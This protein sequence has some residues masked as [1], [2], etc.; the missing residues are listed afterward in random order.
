MGVV[1]P[2]PVV[3]FLIWEA[4]QGIGSRCY[5]YFLC[6]NCWGSLPSLGHVCTSGTTAVTALTRGP[7]VKIERP[8]IAEYGDNV[9]V[10][11][12]ICVFSQSF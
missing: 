7:C 1:N 11:V 9:T 12:S 3:P 2:L 4:A 5:T 6:S 10:F 8:N